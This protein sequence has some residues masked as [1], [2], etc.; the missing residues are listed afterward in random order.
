MLGR[1]LSEVEAWFDPVFA[2]F[3][4]PGVM[5]AR[6]LLD[7]LRSRNDPGLGERGS[8][9]SLGTKSELTGCEMSAEFENPV[10]CGPLAM[11]KFVV[12]PPNVGNASDDAG[13]TPDNGGN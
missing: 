5:S 8:A 6:P 10:D 1:G 11:G 2:G 4:I 13:G 12:T 3:G 7:E 9:V